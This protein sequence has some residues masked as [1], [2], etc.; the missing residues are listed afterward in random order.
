MMDFIPG[1][2]IFILFAS[3][4]M[5]S[6]RYVFKLRKMPGFCYAKSREMAELLIK[7]GA[8]INVRD[9]YN[10]TPLHI[11]IGIGSREAAE[12][13][14]SK[15]ADIYAIDDEGNTPLKL[16]ERMGFTYTADLLRKHG[17]KF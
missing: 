14:I 8:D 12:V 15:G 16:A 2:L 4:A 17:A 3:G 5:V 7:C 9:P 10:S 13:L 11:L 6:Y 1:L